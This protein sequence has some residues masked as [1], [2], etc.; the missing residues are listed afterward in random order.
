MPKPIKPLTY[1]A[2]D[3]VHSSASESTPASAAGSTA[4]AAKPKSK[5]AAK[6]RILPQPDLAPNSKKCKLVTLTASQTEFSDEDS[7]QWQDEEVEEV[8]L[9]GSPSKDSSAPVFVP[10]GLHTP[11][12]EIKEVD[13]TIAEV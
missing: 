6:K 5:Q 8:E 3:E 9:A 12:P 13:E 2:K 4:S 7:H 1:P 10:A 11:R